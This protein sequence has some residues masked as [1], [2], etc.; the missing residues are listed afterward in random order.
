MAKVL[1]S[2]KSHEEC[3][4]PQE[5]DLR[6]AARGSSSLPPGVD[7]LLVKKSFRQGVIFLKKIFT[8]NYL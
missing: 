2:F 6:Q 8:I 4:G 1:H 3:H 5:G 7:S